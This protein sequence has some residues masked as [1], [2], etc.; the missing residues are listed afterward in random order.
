MGTGEKKNR[1]EVNR[2]LNRFVLREGE[3]IYPVRTHPEARDMIIEFAEPVEGL[4]DTLTT[5][6]SIAIFA[7]NLSLVPE[8]RRAELTDQFITP[9][10][11]DNEEGKA[12]IT[13]L[14]EALT[15]RRLDLYPDESF[16]ILPLEDD[17][18]ELEIDDDEGDEDEDE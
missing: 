17:D 6:Y 5:R 18:E 2:V 16:L 13:E 14:V 9:L 3:T 12:V 15:E 1:R 4:F 10:I 7:W 11:G 8:E